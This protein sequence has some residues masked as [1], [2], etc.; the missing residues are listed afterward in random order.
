ML[1][2]PNTRKR[3]QQKEACLLWHRAP[4]QPIGQQQTTHSPNISSSSAESNASRSSAPA[5][6]APSAA[7]APPPMPRS[8]QPGAL[9]ACHRSAN[10]AS[11]CRAGVGV[12]VV[13]GWG[14]VGG[15]CPAT[16]LQIRPQAARVGM[17][18]AVSACL[19]T[20]YYLGVNWVFIKRED[21]WSWRQCTASTHAVSTAVPVVVLGQLHQGQHPLQQHPHPLQRWSTSPAVA[22]ADVPFRSAW[23][24]VPGAACVRRTTPGSPPARPGTPCSNVWPFQQ[25]RDC[26]GG[27]SRPPT[28]A[29]RPAL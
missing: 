21:A 7:A 22:D 1:D 29:T 16:A 25:Q 5:A 11:S 24:A 9:L 8:S 20:C 17:R 2:P 26:D 28:S 4:E 15:A 10:S 19:Q 27:V 3:I 6:A 12:G 23:T 14:G 13:G 18:R